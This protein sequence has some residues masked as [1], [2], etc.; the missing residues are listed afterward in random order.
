MRK[1]LPVRTW[2]ELDKKALL[3]NFNFFASRARGMEIMA[4]IKSNAYGH[5]LVTVA[6]CISGKSKKIW[7]GVDSITEA[8]ALRREKI[9]NPIL[10]LGYTLPNRM[11]EAR[12][13]NVSITISNFESLKALETLKAK[14]AF[15]IKIET[16][17]NRLGFKKADWPKLI[18]RLQKSNLTPDGIYSHLAEATDRKYSKKQIE[19]FR[20]AILSFKNSGIRPKFA[21]ILKTEGILN[22][23]SVGSMVRIGIGLY[24]YIPSRLKNLKPV[25]TWKTMVAE[26]KNVRQGELI[27]YG[28]TEKFRRDSR[29]AVLPIG[30]WHGYD[31]GLSSIGEVLIHGQRV[32]VMGRVSMDMTVVDIT[33]IQNVKVGDEAVL[34]G[35]QGNDYI[36]GDEIADK[37]GTI[38]Y[39]VITRINPL[40]YKVVV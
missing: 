6:R 15:H 17:M 34:L 39:E 19:C 11:K 29:V 28:L 22:F 32:K 27:G 37:I 8:L 7:L 4:V 33:N 25:M 14:P 20:E 2:I 36:S 40:I 12:Q 35:R 21:H 1:T 3:A 23:P 26:V 16:G 5:G 10:V 9:K 18:S 13:N 30:Y 31:R 38:V 24:G